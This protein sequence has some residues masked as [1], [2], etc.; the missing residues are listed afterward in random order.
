MR[1]MVDPLGRP[2]DGRDLVASTTRLPI[3]RA[4]PYIMDRS[5]VTVVLQTGIKVTGAHSDRARPARADPFGS[6]DR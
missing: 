4:A 3:E 5:P 2:A 6:P 1:R